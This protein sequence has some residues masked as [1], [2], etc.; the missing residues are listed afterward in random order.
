MCVTF[1]LR[2]SVLRVTSGWRQGLETTGST[3]GQ[4]WE[5]RA[6]GHTVARSLAPPDGPPCGVL[7]LSSCPHCPP[8]PLLPLWRC[9]FVGIRLDV[10]RSAPASCD[11]RGQPGSL[12]AWPRASLLPVV[13]N[14]NH[15]I[16]NLQH[17]TK[18]LWE[19]TYFEILSRVYKKKK[20]KNLQIKKNP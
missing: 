17:K 6:G 15:L 1:S 5:V 3:E 16:V 4:M 14:P 19:I 8:R 18:S 10:L 9:C 12:E 2:I 7:L 13:K 20:P 11:S